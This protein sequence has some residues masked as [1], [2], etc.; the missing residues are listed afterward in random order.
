MEK[1]LQKKG[2]RRYKERT[3]R[4]NYCS[5]RKNT[6]GHNHFIQEFTPRIPLE[7]TNSPKTCSSDLRSPL[8]YV[9]YSPRTNSQ[10]PV[11]IEKPIISPILSPTLLQIYCIEL[12]GPISFSTWVWATICDPTGNIKKKIKGKLF[13]VSKKIMTYFQRLFLFFFLKNNF[14]S[15]QAK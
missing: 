10:L 13:L 1:N 14:I 7:L 11:I 4:K 6:S 2:I 9:F 5:I 3:L 15:Q 12:I 8:N